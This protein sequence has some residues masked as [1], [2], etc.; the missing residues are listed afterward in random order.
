MSRRHVIQYTS[1]Y[2][3][4]HLIHRSLLMIFYQYHRRRIW[5]SKKKNQ[6]SQYCLHVPHRWD[7]IRAARA[8][9]PLKSAMKRSSSM[10]PTLKSILKRSPVHG[11]ILPSFAVLNVSY[12]TMS[13]RRDESLFGGWINET[14]TRYERWTTFIVVIP[15]RSM[16]D[17][18]SSL[19]G[20]YLAGNSIK[21]TS[22]RNFS[23]QSV[24]KTFLRTICCPT[25]GRFVCCEFLYETWCSFHLVRNA[26]RLV[27]TLCRTRDP[28]IRPWNSYVV[29][30]IRAPDKR[31]NWMTKIRQL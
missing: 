2:D 8:Q 25:R 20:E 3:D 6:V 10:K 27:L 14:C 24:C 22:E 23:P 29:F 18:R 26:K 11:K 5:R 28:S 16:A 21:P 9:M 17:R 19:Q 7:H 13:L 30:L 1:R 4:D 12:L 31:L 15:D